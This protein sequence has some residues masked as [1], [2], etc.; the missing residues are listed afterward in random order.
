MAGPRQLGTIADVFEPL[1]ATSAPAPAVEPQDMGAIWDAAKTYSRTD[2]GDS[3]A[4]RLTRGFEPIIAA[5]NHGRAPD[6]QFEDP[7]LWLQEGGNLDSASGQTGRRPGKRETWDPRTWF[8]NRVTVTEQMEAIFA[9]VRRRRASDPAFLPGIPSTWQEHRKQLL[10]RDKRERAEAGNVLAQARGVGGTLASFGGGAAEIMSD[11]LNIAS[12][13]LGGGAVGGTKSLVLIAGREALLNATLEGLQQPQ[14]ADNRALLGEDLSLGEAAFNVGIAGAFGGAMPFAVRGAGKVGGATGRAAG[15]G[16]DWTVG[17]VFAAMPEGVQA[18]WAAR[19]KVGDMPI[20]EFFAGLSHGE[21]AGFARDVIGLERLSPTERAAV[22][23]LEAADL[24]GATSPYAPGMAGDETHAQQLAISLRNLLENKPLAGAEGVGAREGGGAAASSDAG[25]VGAPSRVVSSTGARGSQTSIPG[26]V[27]GDFD[28]AAVK[29]KIARPESRGNDQATNLAGSSASGR[30]Q[31]VKGTFQGLYARVYG[32]SEGEA[33]RVWGTSRR[34]DVE[35]QERLMDA[36]LDENAAVLRGAGQQPTTGN[37]YLA[38][39]VGGKRAA[40][41]LK[42]DPGTPVARFM[43][44]QEIAQNGSYFS[45]GKSVSEA[46]ATIHSKVGGSAASVPARPGLAG[47]G[48]VSEDPQIAILREEALRLSDIAVGEQVLPAGGTLPAM[49]SMRINPDFVRV[50]AERFQF[51]SGGDAQGVT[52]RLRGVAEWNPVYAGRV[53]LWQDEAGHIFIADGHQRLGLAQRIKGETGADIQL[54]GILMRQADGV[55]AED[56]RT[57]AA[58]KNIAEGTGTAVDAAKVV[59]QAGADVLAHLPPRSALVRDG[60]ALSRLS[61]EAFGAVYNE[62]IPADIAAVVGHLAPDRPEAHAGLV[63][64]LVKLDP[65]NRGQAESIVRQALAAGFHREEQSELFGTRELVSSLFLERAK[66]LERGLSELR[67]LKGAFGTAARN[68]DALEDAGSKIARDQAAKEAQRNAEAIEIIS[69]VAFSKGPV[70]DL[71][72]DAARDLA[73]GAQLGDVVAGFVAGVRKLELRDLARAGADDS[74]RL[75]PD[76]AGRGGDARGEGEQF[77]PE[78]GDQEQPSLL[79]L[80][81]ATARFS[82]PDGQG[83]AEQAE[84][85]FHDLKAGAKAADPALAERQRQQAALKAGSPD[86]ATAEQDGT[87]GL[88]L[89]DAADEPGFSFRLSDEGDE[90]SAAD[91]LAELEADDAAIAALKGCL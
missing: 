55:S 19:M 68:A 37:L 67:K 87:G 30:Y 89:F 16:Y 60:A 39:V 83:V 1:P 84:S 20:A 45:G 58:L 46:I 80:E 41:M 34:F 38:H 42:A 82:D 88:G 79:E 65:A 7:G 62:V 3:E 75:A 8:A 21:A 50:D 47:G 76:G 54:D 36:L 27:G 15:A 29:A 71:L 86:R 66:V 56:A 81:A 63:D 77:P 14:V 5:I 25:P 74:G 33:A 49:R 57:W 26:R 78:R 48:M 2:R 53:V 64:L 69:R 10:E 52:E 12:L 43:T 44:E 4:L 18:K 9:E 85:L 11:P 59:R 22:N 31:F 40:A 90:I 24:D 32:V 72:N 61:D 23:T 17:K 91:L 35:V 51:K 6:D 73:A 70:S 28:R 13:P